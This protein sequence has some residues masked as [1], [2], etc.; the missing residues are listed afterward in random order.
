[1][2]KA[3]SLE[4]LMLDLVNKERAEAGLDP[5]RLELRL[6]ASAEDH[7][8]WMIERDVFSH[9]GA[10]G[11]NA[12]DRMRDADFAFE[13]RWTWGE[14]IALQSERGASGLADD[15]A[16]LHRGLMNS[17]GHRANILKPEFE[18]LGIGV[19]RGDYKGFD[20]VVV[21]QNFA[22]SDAAMRYDGGGDEDGG[23]GGGARPE[24]SAP[25]RAP[26]PEPEPKVAPQRDEGG[27]S[28]PLLVADDFELRAGQFHRLAKR[29]DYQDADGDR[30]VRI[31]IDGPDAGARVI[32][33][34]ETVDARDGHVFDAD[35]LAM[36]TIR[37]SPDG[38]DQDFRVRAHDGKEWGDWD[39]FTITASNWDDLA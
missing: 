11:S 37:F 14:N 16:D 2:S 6:N 31:E 4:R 17:P 29:L 9:T 8:A 5:L 35:D 25:K 22:R 12:G 13:G 39:G 28:A 21:T 7:S 30:A 19:E 10:G 3:D 38:E 15:V 18:V 34:R 32:V 20:A 27:N 33:N 23:G 36:L 1:M 24:P 26:E